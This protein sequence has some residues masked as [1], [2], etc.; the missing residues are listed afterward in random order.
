MAEQAAAAPTAIADERLGD[1]LKI[2]ML[3]ALVGN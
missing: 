3:L 1:P 2:L